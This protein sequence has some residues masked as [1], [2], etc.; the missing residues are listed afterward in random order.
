MLEVTESKDEEVNGTWSF[1]LECL[2]ENLQ[3]WAQVLGNY[4]TNLNG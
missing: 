1:L 2:V 3:F 4:Y